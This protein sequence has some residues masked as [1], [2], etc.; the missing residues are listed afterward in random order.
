[1]SS[2]DKAKLA[3]AMFGKTEYKFVPTVEDLK[4][5]MDQSGCSEE[6]A[7]IFFNKNK[8]DLEA[9]IIDYLESSDVLKKTVKKNLISDEELLNESLSLDDKMDTYR[10]I[11]YQKDKVFQANFDETSD[12]M[13]KTVNNY[14]YVAFK[15][16]TKDHRK[17]KF[18][19]S[20]ELFSMDIIRPYIECE[21]DDIKLY[22]ISQQKYKYNSSKGGIELENDVK[23]SI[24]KP[25]ENDDEDKPKQ[26][27]LE[28]TDK[29]DNKT[30]NENKAED[31]N[32]IATIPEKKIILKTIVKKGLNMAKKWGCSKPVLA[33]MEV[34]EKDRTD[35]TFNKLATKFMVNS[36]HFDETQKIYGPAII[37]DNWIM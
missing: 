14:D 12:L 21:I 20:K 23:I 27:A 31:E 17:L 2:S 22:E 34:E 33:Y 7:N 8:G 16:D 6:E 26:K 4:I 36:G 29:E 11:L 5:I 28:W 18:K 30:E 37:I 1:M 35:E 24:A 32:M 25:D 9:T 3:N 10:E 13:K 19:G 15:S